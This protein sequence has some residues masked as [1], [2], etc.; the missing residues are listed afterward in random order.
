MADTLEW[1]LQAANRGGSTCRAERVA[2]ERVGVCR[3]PKGGGYYGGHIAYAWRDGT[4]VYHL[5]AH[6]YPTTAG[7][8]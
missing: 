1:T 4:L 6:G 2:G 8:G 5:T 3:V 7:C